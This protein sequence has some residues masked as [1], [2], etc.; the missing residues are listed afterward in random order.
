MSTFR[1]KDVVRALGKAID[2]LKRAITTSEGVEEPP[3][4]PKAFPVVAERLPI[5]LKVLTCIQTN[6]ELKK[7]DQEIQS[8]QD[9]FLETIHA[10]GECTTLAGRLED[11]FAEV[12]GSED[13]ITTKMNRYRSAVGSDDTI[14]KVMKNLLGLLV[15]LA[16]APPMSAEDLKELKEALEEVRKLPA[17]LDTEAR[18]GPTLNN[19]GNGIQ[20]GH[21]GTGHQNLNSAGG[22]QLTGNNSHATLNYKDSP[23]GIK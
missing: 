16:K 20:L 5:A 8:V 10:A 2:P 17:S 6:L 14:E 1:P 19:Y 13:D 21:F 23:G 9:A 11:L 3:G 7:T 12:E 4:L 18:M 22:V 15:Q